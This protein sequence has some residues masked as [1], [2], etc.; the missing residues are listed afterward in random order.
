MSGAAIAGAAVAAV[1]AA[2]S[3]Y[4]SRKQ[5]K[6]QRA[7]MNQ[8][9]KSAAQARHDQQTA[10]NRANQNEVNL[11]SIYNQAQGQ[12]YPT[13]LTSPTGTDQKNTTLG[14]GSSLLGG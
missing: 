8:Q 7:A 12:D 1:S 10:F 9:A 3:I 4:S 13:L 14:G 11:E 5:A 6:A 2:A